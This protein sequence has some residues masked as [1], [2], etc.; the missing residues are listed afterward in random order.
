MLPQTN[1]IKVFPGGS[2]LI[3]GGLVGWGGVAVLESPH[4]L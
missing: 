2:V 1:I 4:Y 3:G